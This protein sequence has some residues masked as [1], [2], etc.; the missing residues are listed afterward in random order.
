MGNARL[1]KYN[2][3]KVVDFKEWD[4]FVDRSP[5][6]TIFSYAYYLQLAVDHWSI[7]W[8]KKGS[9]IKAG[10]VLVLNDTGDK[11]ILD[12]LVVHNG[13][14][15]ASS[16][17]QKEAKTRSERFKIT[18][19]IIE[20]ME[21][22][23]K[24]IQISLSPQTEDLRPYLWHNFHSTKSTDRFILDLRYTSY[25]NISS[26]EGNLEEETI[27]FKNL[28][29]LRQRNIREARKARVQT[30]VKGDG[31]LFVKHFQ[32]MMQE[33]GE[34]QCSDKMK[35]LERLIDGL[36][37][38]QKG[39]VFLTQNSSGEIIYISVFGWD[40]KRAYYL[41]GTSIK[42]VTKRYQGTISFWDAFLWLSRQGV[43]SV[44]MEGINSP[45]RG[46]FKLSFG[47][48]LTSYYEIFK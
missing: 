5:Q 46:W 18:E 39:K 11:A 13:L 24:S 29:T 42:G 30:L 3:E 43:C 14:M 47:G 12:D 19:F 27:L 31:G 35:R 22:Q 37:E 20:W 7:Y 45:K 8:I 41:F 9:Q 23:F 40:N 38:S 36:V 32:S 21:S 16:N 6:G 2:I 10:L 15:F 17:D 4:Q 26:L 28:E 48:E 1:S 34:L 44:D 33:R 25:L